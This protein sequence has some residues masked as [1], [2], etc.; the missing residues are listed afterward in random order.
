MSPESAA[1]RTETRSGEAIGGRGRLFTPPAWP[2]GAYGCDVP[3]VL[4]AGLAV[5]RAGGHESREAAVRVVEELSRYVDGLP[6]SDRA[7]VAR[8]LVLA[9]VPRRGK[10]ASEGRLQG[11]T[12]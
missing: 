8:Q 11:E 10:S 3:R 7:A 5:D 9:L 6:E 2:I 1:Q 4:R 12:P